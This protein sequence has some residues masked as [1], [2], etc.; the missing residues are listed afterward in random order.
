MRDMCGPFS[1]AKASIKARRSG[2]VL[3]YAYA[4]SYLQRGGFSAGERWHVYSKSK[5]T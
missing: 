2:S 4:R 5:H 1:S 3:L